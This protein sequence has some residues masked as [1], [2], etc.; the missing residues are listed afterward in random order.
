MFCSATVLKSGNDLTVFLF[1]V[2]KIPSSCSFVYWN[3]ERESVSV[4]NRIKCLTQHYEHQGQLFS[5]FLHIS[6]LSVP[7]QQYKN[8][9]SHLESKVPKISFFPA[10]ISI[11]LSFPVLYLVPPISLLLVSFQKNPFL[12][13]SKYF[14]FFNMP[15]F[16]EYMTLSWHPL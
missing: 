13:V 12:K 7:L 9:N 4:V 16:N 11:T 5:G 6:N 14:T 1:S 2:L 10:P 15:R 8:K 3:R